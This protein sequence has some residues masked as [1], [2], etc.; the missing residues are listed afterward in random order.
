MV[1]SGTIGTRRCEPPLPRELVEVLNERQD[2]AVEAL[3]VRVRRLDHV[4]LV[5]RM[6]PAAVAESEVAGGQFQRLAGEDVTRVR[7]RVARPEHGIYS[8]ALEDRHLGLDEPSRRRGARRVVAACDVDLQVA[9]A[10]GREVRL[11]SG[12]RVVL[13]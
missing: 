12:D 4:V 11:Q 5:R 2:G 9:E 1:R 8:G 3:Y 13:A 10:A 6:G 7:A